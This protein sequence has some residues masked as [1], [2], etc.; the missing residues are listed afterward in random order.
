VKSTEAYAALR[1]EIGPWAKRHGFKRAN[2]M[3]SWW[4]PQSD[5]CVVFWCQVF[6][7]A[8]DPFAGS[9]FTV[10]FQL[11]LEPVVGCAGARR[12]RIA[13]LL[14]GAALEELRTIQNGVIASLPR[15]P[16]NHP[17]LQMGGKAR[18]SY[19]DRFRPIDAPYS[20][21][22][23]VWLRYRCE[24]DV[25]RWGR[26]VLARLPGCLSQVQGWNQG[27]ASGRGVTW[28][29]LP[30]GGTVADS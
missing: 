5:R 6:R 13:R 14:D 16:R 4:R 15:P 23:D 17:V 26:F 7:G 28:V 27:D 3:L 2:A 20:S 10:E 21:E 22:Q 25:R 1:D 19:L 18:E 8:W 29:D 11:C 24:A 12:A 9:Q 30:G